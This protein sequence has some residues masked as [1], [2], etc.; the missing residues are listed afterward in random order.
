MI[1]R[2]GSPQLVALELGRKASLIVCDRGY[3]RHQKTWRKTLSDEAACAVVQVESDTVIPVEEVSTRAEYAA[4]TIRPKIHRK[5]GAYLVPV[6]P[7]RVNHPSSSLDFRGE[8]LSHLQ[9]ILRKVQANP[10]VG[11]VSR[12]F[13]GGTEEAKKRFRAFLDNRLKN[14]SDHRNQP[15]T[16]DFSGV[17]PYLHFGQVSPLYL[18]LEAQKRLDQARRGIETFLEE[19]LVRREL[20]INHTEYT[21]DYDEYSCIPSWSARTLEKHRRDVRPHQ[22][23]PEQLEN[24]ESH[25]PYWNASMLEMRHTGFMHNYMR[26]Y[27]GKRILEWSARPEEAFAVTLSLNN[28]Y[29]LDGRDP[30]SYAGV[31]WIFGLHDRPW[32]ERP[33][34]G[35]V[36]CMTAAGL[37]RKCDIKGYVEKIDRLVER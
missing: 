11:P 7:Q 24:A 22:Y 4:R 5:V 31:G 17:S 10:E 23:T 15:Q 18:A 16:D 14:Y 6:E 25:D 32:K 36:R 9:R 28:K 27:W 33:I 26:M 19:L 13:G 3:L 21:T 12:F 30:N 34:F 29:F 2:L 8:D 20:S 1:V 35:T 37:E